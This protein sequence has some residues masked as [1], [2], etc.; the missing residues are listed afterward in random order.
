M[1][2]KLD[3]ELFRTK[4]MLTM[5]SELYAHIF[6]FLSGTMDWIMEKRRRKLLDSF[7]ENFRRRFDKEISNITQISENIRK[8]AEQT[9]RVEMRV[10]RMVVEDIRRDIRVGL[11]GDARYQADT[12]IT[13][14][15]LDREMNSMRKEYREGTKQLAGLLKDMLHESAFSSFQA[16]R[17]SYLPLQLF[18][19][20]EAREIT[21]GN[22][23][24]GN[25]ESL[26]VQKIPLKC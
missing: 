17:D 2:L 18:A 15:R 6:L 16:R 13:V 4:P 19:V 20:P 11:E 21:G 7:N 24:Y 14:D 22:L 12:K 3:V 25:S 9:S 23:E 26:T 10:T 5:I 1:R 8:L